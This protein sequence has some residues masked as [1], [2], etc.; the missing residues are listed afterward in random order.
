MVSIE[1]AYSEVERILKDNE[2]KL[3][4]IKILRP[5]I[6]DTY[7]DMLKIRDKLKNEIKRLEY[8]KDKINKK[9]ISKEFDFIYSNFNI[10]K[11]DLLPEKFKNYEELNL[12]LRTKNYHAY[13]WNDFLDPWIEYYEVLDKIRYYFKEFRNKAKTLNFYLA[14]SGIKIEFDEKIFDDI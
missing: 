7:H 10:T 4:S 13:P 9:L 12:M 5:L 2:Q 8:I 14:N 3:K 6:N 1:K 11:E